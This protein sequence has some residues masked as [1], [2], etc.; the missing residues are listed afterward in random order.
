M[1]A[2]TMEGLVGAKTS[3]DIMKVP[4]RVFKEARR[5]GDTATME[6][7]MGYANDFAVKAEEYKNEADE[8]M[9]KDAEEAK[10][11]A[12]KAREK[13]IEKRKEERE[14]LEERIEE[15]RE[16]GDDKVEISEAGKDLLQGNSSEEIVTESKGKTNSV[17]R[18]PVTYTKEG[19]TN[20]EAGRVE[21]GR[22]KPIDLFA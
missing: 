12:E 3:H 6:R 8:G 7:A 14:R 2:Q 1:H 4:V 9:K 22:R 18:E 21:S 19:K 16:T 17:N 11:K 13:L 20:T 10:E 5:R 15:S